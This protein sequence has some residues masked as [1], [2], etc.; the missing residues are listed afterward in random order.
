MC[1]HLH[2][3]QGTMTKERLWC[4]FEEK[5]CGNDCC[6]LYLYIRFICILFVHLDEEFKRKE[7]KET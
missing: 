5:N 4:D 3:F 2:I 6:V 7:E 1:S